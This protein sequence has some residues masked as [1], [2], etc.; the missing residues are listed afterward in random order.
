MRSEILKQRQG[1]E[2]IADL[3]ALYYFTGW[4]RDE[5]RTLRWD[6][7][8]WFRHTIT[9]RRETTKAGEAWELPFGGFPFL[10]EVLER[11]RAA[12]RAVEKETGRAVPWVFHRRGRPVAYFRDTWN[13]ACAAA[14][15]KRTPHDCRRT[16]ARRLAS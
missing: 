10:V 4:R 5:A 7:V 3:A 2:V 13:A 14:G 11:R 6:Q 8:N 1:R 15:V 9:L 16:A 12:T